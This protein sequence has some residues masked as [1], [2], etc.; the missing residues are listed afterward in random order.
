MRFGVGAS[1]PTPDATTL[2]RCAR[3]DHGPP[4]LAA[5]TR[6]MPAAWACAPWAW[7]APTRSTSW[8]ACPGSSS[9]PRRAL[10]GGRQAVG[11]P[12]LA[13]DHVQLLAGMEGGLLA[14]AGGG[15]AG[16]A[17][18]ASRWAEHPRRRARR[19]PSRALG[20]APRAP[21][22]SPHPQVI[23]VKLTGKLSK[24]TSPKDVILK[25]AGILTVKVRT[26]PFFWGGACACLGELGSR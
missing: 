10:F 26:A 19:A 23:G 1:G 18:C 14:G 5:A 22:T 2:S 24:W 9:A 13:A 17:V 12:G 16:A 20:S 3:P 7:A 21:H 11:R 4:L 8:P 6:P 25:V 15:F